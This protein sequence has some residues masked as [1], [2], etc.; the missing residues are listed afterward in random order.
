MLNN[1]SACD[2]F[3][4]VTRTGPKDPE[5]KGIVGSGVAFLTETLGIHTKSGQPER[6]CIKTSP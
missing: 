2:N 3:R 6:L 1:G 5:T 4:S